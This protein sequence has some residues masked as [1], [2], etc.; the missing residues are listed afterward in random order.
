MSEQKQNR[1]QKRKDRALVLKLTDHNYLASQ[2][3]N[4]GGKMDDD[5][6]TDSEAATPVGSP[7]S[8]PAFKVKRKE[9][10]DLSLEDLQANILAA[11]N[12][13]ADNLEMMVRDNKSGI[14]E[15]KTSMNFAFAEIEALKNDNKKLSEL[16]NSNEK[17]IKLME[18]RLT[19]TE[20]Y[21]RRWSLRLYGLPEE[22]EENVKRKVIDIC[23]QI[24]PN[25]N[26]NQAIDV[27]HRIGRRDAGN[28]HPRSVIILFAF[29]TV[30][31]DTWKNARKHT[32][33]REK[34]L[35]FGEDLTQAD[36]KTRERLW[37]RIE[38]A[39]KQG[40]RAFFRGTRAFIEDVE[41]L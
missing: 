17:T 26:M 38:E 30:R 34:R 6:S 31:D 41:I 3:E 8:S 40:K 11:V 25:Q 19:E 12:Q 5:F 13:R 33:L 32:F 35:R 36:K 10:S 16:C 18:I 14:E 28:T 29:R 1:K 7:S 21:R 27:V 2:K 23:Q 37:P 15:L 20:R 39:R 22:K 4:N 9:K 24:A